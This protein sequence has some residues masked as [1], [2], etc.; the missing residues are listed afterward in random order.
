M[1]TSF[2]NGISGVKTQQFALDVLGDN[3]SNIGTN[4]F[5]GKTPEFSTIFSTALTD[6]Y[7][8]PTSND[9]GLGS[10]AN[11]AS[12]NTYTQGEF[13]STDRTFDLALDGEG[14]FGVQNN[15]DSTL[16]T[17]NGAFNI[18]ANGNL[19]DDGGNY[20]LGTLGDNITP[21][22]LSQKKLEDF[23]TYYKADTKEL[24]TPYQIS[25]ISDI[26]LGSATD[27]SKITLPDILYYPP[28][29]T[30]YVNYQANL[31]PKVNEGP[32]QV[33]LNSADIVA[34]P[35]NTTNQTLTINGTVSNTPE[36]QNPKEADVVLVTITDINGKTVEAKPELDS[37]L[38]WIVSD[39]DVSSLDT[40]NPLT[41]SAK[42][43]TTQEI[44]NE[45]HFTTEIISPTGEKS[46]VD[47][48]FTKQVPQQSLEST[49]DAKFQVLQYFEDYKVET[50]DPNITYDPAI[51]D[52]NTQTNQ[53]KKIYDPSLY[54]V[55]TGQNKV[56]KIIDSQTGSATFDGGGKLLQS[57]MPTLSNG[58]TSLNLNI[59]TPYATQNVVSSQYTISGNNLTISGT[60]SG[61][62]AGKSVQ[63]EVNDINNHTITTNATV[64]S[65]GSWS[66]TYE[67]NTLDTSQ[68]LNVNAYNII[69]NGF[70]GIISNV[71]LNKAKVS[72]KDG[73]PE[74][75]L[76]NYGMDT[77]G[78]IIAD[79]SNGKS[80]PIA[81]IAVY[82]FRNPQGLSTVTSTLYN[83]TTNSGDALFYTDKNGDNFLGSRIRSHNLESSNVSFNTALTELIITQ[84]AFDASA[85]SIT[86]SDQMIQNAI[87][88]KK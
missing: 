71:N 29:A 70:D 26:T 32:T 83:A 56:Y 31:D 21:T 19:V 55:D 50:Y 7:F 46:F 35:P 61:I 3:I 81:K 64:Q 76:N 60:T 45:E 69:S 8:D 43:Q 59:G 65:D 77:K 66:T 58:G 42:L 52:V 9:L 38:N 27:Q 1:N 41:V 44:P 28:E 17:R 49:W 73:T 5:I 15:A 51:Y 11:A 22:T 34:D 24:G 82:H 67:N 14:W 20:L 79:F 75:I 6:N 57:D 25:K 13:Q 39:K 88:M 47:M 85:K 53:V 16:Y 84:K 62:E 87:N 4:G 63:I 40:T 74:G 48:T 36:L 2:Y 72:K 78:N 30:T 10:Q 68:A 80:I 12:L 37:N 54:K 18:D 23:G 33:D 86:T